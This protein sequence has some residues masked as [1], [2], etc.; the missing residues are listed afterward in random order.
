MMRSLYSCCCLLVLLTLL[1][2]GLYPLLITVVAQTVLPQQANGSLVVENGRVIGSTLIGQE[3]SKAENFWPRPSA[4]AY[5]AAASSGSNLSPA[6]AAHLEAVTSRVQQLNGAIESPV[7][8]DLVT[9]SAS[10]LDPHISPAAARFQIPRV[11]LA[12]GITEAKLSEV[13]SSHVEGRTF[14]L[15][16]ERRVNVLHLNRAL[17]AMGAVK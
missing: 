17:D 14:G 13:V 15:L 2:G 16:G 8:A 6:G 12:R 11:A 1:T 3:F 5:N 9:T 7:P 4:V 10:G